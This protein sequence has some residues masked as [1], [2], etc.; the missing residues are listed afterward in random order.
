MTPFVSLTERDER[1]MLD[2]IGVSSV[3]ELFRDVPDGVRFRREHRLAIVLRE[4]E[5]AQESARTCLYAPRSSSASTS[6]GS[7]SRIRISQPS[8]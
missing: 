7:E 8:P 5:L 6:D 1:E 2:A 3:D 4:G